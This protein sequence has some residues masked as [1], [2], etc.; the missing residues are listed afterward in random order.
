MPDYG[1]VGYWDARYAGQQKNKEELFDWY[2][3]Y[4]GALR[5]ILAPYL[6]QD[7]DFEIFVPGCGNSELSALLYQEGYRN[8][9]NVDKSS[10]LINY[11]SGKYAHMAEMEYSIMDATK[12]DALPSK[13]FDLIID[14][15]LMDALLCGE[16]SARDVPRM[17]SEMFRVL[18]DGGS[19]VIV[20]HGAPANRL[21]FLEKNK[22]TNWTVDYKQ[23]QKPRVDGFEDL[24]ASPFHFVYIMTKR[25]N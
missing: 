17:V 7:L 14:K 15:A 5:N 11:M 21:P 24:G 16:E 18:K 25:L 20:S 13:C 3:T 9:T 2:Q 12:L 10:V 8:I 23:L 1:S 19:Y 22:N 6:R 4:D